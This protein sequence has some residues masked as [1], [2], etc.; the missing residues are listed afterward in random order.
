LTGSSGS[1]S[2]RLATVADAAAIAALHVASWRSAYRGAV[3]GDY[4]DAIDVA[5]HT[6]QWAARLSAK[7]TVFVAETGGELVGFCAVGPSFDEDADTTTWLIAN[8][9]V[10]PDVRSQGVGGRLFDDAIAEARR[11]GATLV[12]LW[13]LEANEG[14]R[15]F[16]ER[17]G[18]T[19]D[20]LRTL[21]PFS[22]DINV[23]MLRYSLAVN[24]FQRMP[25]S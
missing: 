2:H 3:P 12:T 9:H 4:L 1:P 14:A 20:G 13:V 11:A 19:V 22:P 21:R 16:Y 6:A 7:P 23:W 24:Q 10:R 5:D 17:R 18:M 25:L 8:L 15:R